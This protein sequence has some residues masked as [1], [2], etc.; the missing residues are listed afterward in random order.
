MYH[1]ERRPSMKIAL[2]IL[3]GI[4][5]VILTILYGACKFTLLVTGRVLGVLSVILAILG[6]VML[7]TGNTPGGAAFLIIALIICPFGLPL[8]A[9]VTVGRLGGMARVLRDYIMG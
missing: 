9:A 3:A 5:A 1:T 6:M 8:L 2:L 4:G 7:A